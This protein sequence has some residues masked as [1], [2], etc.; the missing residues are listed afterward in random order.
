[1]INQ[2][3]VYKVV[4]IGAGNVATHL[5]KRLQK[6]GHEILQVISKSEKSARDLSLLLS[7]SYTTDMAKINKQANVYIFCIPDTE[8]I[9][10]ASTL[11]LPG[12]LVLHTSGSLRVNALKTVSSNC[13]VLYPLYS[14]SK[15]V[16][17]SF[18]AIPLLIEGATKNSLLQVSHLAHSIGKNVSTV[19]S[20]QRLKL[21]VAAVFVNNFTNFLY[22]QAY[23]YLKGEKLNNFHLLQPLI[24]QTVKKIK[25]MPPAQMQ[26]G[27]A[28]RNDKATLQK[29]MDLLEKYPSQKQVYKLISDLI[30]KQYNAG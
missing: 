1:M 10:I 28:R 20:D 13:G 22:G 2:S 25:N 4:M 3:G 26:T 11:K 5:A 15:Q 24:K 18:S 16:K 23:D 9:S 7:S 14:F 29:H 21:H 6:K 8:I 30:K 17:V 27:P 19:N 12:K